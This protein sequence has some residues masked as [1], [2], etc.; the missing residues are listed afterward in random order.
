MYTPHPQYAYG[1]PAGQDPPPIPGTVTVVR[2]L[3]FLGGCLGVLTALAAAV[4]LGAVMGMS[5]GEVSDLS[6]AQRIA[7][8]FMADEGIDPEVM[9]AMIGLVIGVP[10]ATGLISL[11]LAAVAG[12]RSRMW[13]VCI[14]VFQVL[15]A[16]GYLLNLLFLNLLALV[17]LALCILKICLICGSQARAYYAS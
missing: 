4:L 1:P 11:F 3:M 14:T 5:P 10:G 16:L 6:D 17:P 15:L 8:E 12:R 9:A 7:V 13:P 2:V